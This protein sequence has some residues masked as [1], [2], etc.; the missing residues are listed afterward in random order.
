[1]PLHCSCIDMQTMTFDF[2]Y[3]RVKPVIDCL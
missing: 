1:M 2:L 3:L